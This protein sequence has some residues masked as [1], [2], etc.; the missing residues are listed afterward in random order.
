MIWNSSLS[1]HRASSWTQNKELETIEL[2]IS[3]F[4]NFVLQRVST[5]LAELVWKSFLI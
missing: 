1:I 4:P 2:L 5:S 3:L